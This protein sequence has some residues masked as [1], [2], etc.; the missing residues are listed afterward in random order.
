RKAEALTHK[1]PVAELVN[2]FQ[3][4]MAYVNWSEQTKIVMFNRKLKPDLRRAL[5][6]SPKK[7]TFDEW[8]PIV[9]DKDNELHELEVDLRREEKISKPKATGNGR[10]SDRSYSS[11][12]WR[13]SDRPGTSNSPSQSG[14]SAPD[15]NGPTPMEVDALR[16]AP[17]GPL[18]PEERAYRDANG[19]CRYCG[20]KH[21]IAECP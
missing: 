8:A 14:T 7:D 2:Q 4:C 16:Q 17:R 5:L 9:I 10:P 19:L 15:T 13:S 6:A 18:T 21:K 12:S 11:P 20:G 1:G 3:E